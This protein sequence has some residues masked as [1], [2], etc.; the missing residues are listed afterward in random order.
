MTLG[1]LDRATQSVGLGTPSG[2]V[3]MTG[4]SGLALGG[5]LGWLN[6]RHGLTCDN[7]LAADVVTAAG[8]LSPRPPRRIRI[9]SGRCV[10]AAATS[11]SSPRSSSGCTRS[12]TFWLA[13]SPIRRIKRGL[14]CAC[15]ASSPRSV[16]MSSPPTAL[17]PTPRTAT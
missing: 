12:A 5:G 11:A 10:E 4:L 13:T 9:C 7:L 16:P 17:W 3:S 2:V 6:G 15:T 8:A 14:P 1:D